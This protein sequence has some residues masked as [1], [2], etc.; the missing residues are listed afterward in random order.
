MK[1]IIDD[2]FFGK[3]EMLGHYTI[4]ISFDEPN[5]E[6]SQYYINWFQF[7]KRQQ[8]TK[9]I[10]GIFDDGIIYQFLGCYPIEIKERIK[11]NPLKKVFLIKYN[12]YK[13][14]WKENE[15]I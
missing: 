13:V 14:I 2:Y 15:F 5:K 4:R 7:E 11:N 8:F 10:I 3:M 12:E 1:I 9:S 6:F